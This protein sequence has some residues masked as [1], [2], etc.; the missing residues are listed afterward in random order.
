VRT[1]SIRETRT[2]TGDRDGAINE[3]F[4]HD[5]FR[6]TGASQFCVADI[7]GSGKKKPAPCDDAGV[8]R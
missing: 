2:L 4:R 3:I 1:N 6:V 5:K 8:C 7:N